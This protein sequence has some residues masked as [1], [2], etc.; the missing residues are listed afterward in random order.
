MRYDRSRI[1]AASVLAVL[2]MT[3][4]SRGDEPS[5]GP[6]PAKRPKATANG[7]G[8]L[9]RYRFR[10]NQLLHYEVKHSSTITMTKAAAS[11]VARST[12]LTRKHYKVT[13]VDEQGNAVLESVID[14]VKM[15]VQFDDGP[16][17]TYDSDDRGKPPREFAGVAQ[18]IGI[19]LARLKFAPSGRL[20]D[21]KPLLEKAV[22]TQV[23]P[24]RGPAPSAAD[25]SRNFLVVFPQKALKVGDTWTNRDLK[26]RLLVQSSP[27]LSRDHTILR[28][29][30]LVS[31]NDGKATIRYSMTPVPP[32]KDPRL[33]MQLIQRVLSGTI[34]FDI[35]RGLIVS[36]KMAGDNKVHGL[37]QGQ[38]L[39]RAESR[40]AERFLPAA[41][42][43]GGSKESAHD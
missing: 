2:L 24:N 7:E 43:A 10:P 3:V 6:V 13:S 20:L 17:K 41:K 39:L 31:V 25:A 42:V 11:T 34:V 9:L 29:Y 23:T 16:I 27:R 22:Q 30:K 40:H 38:G 4:P 32:V 33:Q 15:S 14:S 18:T 36:R 8:W 26:A 19:P 12:T 21:A 28:I 5:A 35:D 1:P 37:A